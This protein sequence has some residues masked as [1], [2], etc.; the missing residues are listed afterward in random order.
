M[1]CEEEGKA[2]GCAG[3]A[4]FVVWMPGFPRHFLCG[5][6]VERMVENTGAEDFGRIRVEGIDE[7]AHGGEGQR[8]R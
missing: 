1:R 6:C 8:R 4:R 7:H 5:R 2:S 3:A